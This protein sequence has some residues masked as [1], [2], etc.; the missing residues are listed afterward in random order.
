VKKRK[1]L[2]EPADIAFK[3][4]GQ[5]MPGWENEVARENAGI[6]VDPVLDDVV[7]NSRY[8][9]RGRSCRVFM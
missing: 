2:V 5:G 9:E 3:K 4:S 8:A 6:L 1:V 7:V